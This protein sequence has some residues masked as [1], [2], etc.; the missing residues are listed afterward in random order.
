MRTVN[1][2]LIGYGMAG[3]VF[4]APVISSVAGLRL[5]SVVERSGS[6]AKER[7]P[8]VKI[9]QSAEALVK[10]AEIEMIVIATPNTSH[11]EL[12]ALALEH[13]K[14]VVVDKPFTVS[15]REAQHL[16]SLAKRKG[17]VLSVFHNR[18]WDGDFLTVR[19]LL[20]EG[21]L[22]RVVSYEAHFDRYRPQLKQG[23]WREAA[24]PGS[25]LLYDLGSHLIDQA[26]Q[27]FGYPQTVIASCSK[28]RE[29][30]Q[31]DDAF[32]VKLG[33]AGLQVVLKASALVRELGP[34]FAIHGTLGSFVKF[35]MDPQ[36]DAL[37]RGELPGSEQWGIER[38]EQWGIWNGEV[39]GLPIRGKVET[40]PGA[41]EDYY[42]DIYEAI[43]ESREPAVKPEEAVAVIRCIELALESHEKQQ[44]VAFRLQLD[45]E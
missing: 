12:A 1:V 31:A 28:Q 44:A 6:T 43:I 32:E 36:E 2:G 30:V 13:G 3:R 8:D 17:L 10:D 33:Y 42:T 14:H 11:A 29:G 9:V 38:E 35:G 15:T 16:I 24:L 20:H 27:L 19:K 34:H 40:L 23:A 21:T 41:Y 25:G 7:Y 4:H 26:F 18:R 37:K 22:G 5:H 39:A 45:E